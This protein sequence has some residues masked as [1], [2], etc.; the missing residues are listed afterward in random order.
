MVPVMDAGGSWSRDPAPGEQRGQLLHLIAY[1]GAFHHAA[2]DG[3]RNDGFGPVGAR[4]KTGRRFF[5]RLAPTSGAGEQRHPR[6]GADRRSGWRRDRALGLRR[7][8]GI[9]GRLRRVP[10]SRPPP[11]LCRSRYPCRQGG[12]GSVPDSPFVVHFRS[13]L[14]IRRAQKQCGKHGFRRARVV[15][16]RGRPGVARAL[17]PDPR[18]HRRLRA[19][20]S[21]GR[22]GRSIP[23]ASF[24]PPRGA[25]DRDREPSAARA[26]SGGQHFTERF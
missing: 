2:R 26:A 9:Y 6:V 20:W 21:S 19:S 24:G 14:Q 8:T 4:P 15:C 22:A 13:F 7:G 12:G 3:A 5:E 16:Q 18:R 17:D 25:P 11:G 10:D 1:H 23:V